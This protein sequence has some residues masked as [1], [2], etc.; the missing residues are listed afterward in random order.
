MVL[1][2]IAPGCAGVASAVRNNVR[3]G[4]LPQAFTA[5]TDSW[6]EVADA[7]TVI[8]LEVLLPVHPAGSDHVYEVAFGTAV[9]ANVWLAPAH[10]LEL[11]MMPSGCAGS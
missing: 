4:L 1:P 10:T 11:P 6:P 7:F 9:M 8:V 2:E 5:I 3:T